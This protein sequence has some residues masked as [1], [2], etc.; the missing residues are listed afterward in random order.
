MHTAAER[1]C[2]QHVQV[3]L[4]AGA[5]VAARDTS[6]ASPLFV[7]AEAGR[8]AAVEVLLAAGADALVGNTAGETALY[9]A[10]ELLP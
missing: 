9:I 1:G 3:L 4:Q 2:A 7:A 6:G 10:G 8:A 5:A